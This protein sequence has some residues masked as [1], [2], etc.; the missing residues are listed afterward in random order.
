[1]CEQVTQARKPVALL[2]AVVNIANKVVA[3]AA[4][5]SYFPVRAPPFASALRTGVPRDLM[6]AKGASIALPAIKANSFVFADAGSTANRTVCTVVH[7]LATAFAPAIPTLIGNTFVRAFLAL[8]LWAAYLA[9]PAVVSMF[10]TALATA[11]FAVIR[12]AIVLALLAHLWHGCWYRLKQAPQ[13][14]TPSISY[15]ARQLNP[16]PTRPSRSRWS[17]GN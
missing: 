4:V 16:A 6:L 5:G 1:M 9:V 3:L 15:S 12:D 8:I 7:V 10:A 17:P 2:L 14:L 11:K 13:L